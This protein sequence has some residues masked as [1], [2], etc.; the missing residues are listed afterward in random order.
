MLQAVPM[1]AD[2]IVQKEGYELKKR[3]L[4]KVGTLSVTQ[5]DESNSDSELSNDEVYEETLE[6]NEK[7]KYSS[8]SRSRSKSSER[9]G[10]GGE[11]FQNKKNHDEIIKSILSDLKEE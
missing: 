2:E 11:W 1:K 4:E 7:G 9:G 5:Y 3:W 6:V 8:R 10:E